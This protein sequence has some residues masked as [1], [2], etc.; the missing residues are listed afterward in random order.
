MPLLAGDRL[1]TADGRVEILFADGSTLHLDMRS[2]IDVQSDDLVRLLGGPRAADT[3]RARAGTRGLSHRLPRPARR[4]SRSRAST[5][6]RC[7]SGGRG[8]DSSSSRWCA[9]RPSSSPIEARPRVRAGERAYASAG[10]APSYAYA[11]NSAAWD[12]FDRWSEAQRDVRLGVS[13]QYLPSDMQTYASTVRRD[14]DW[15]Y[16]A[17]VRLR[18]GIRASPPTG[19]LIT[20]GA[21]IRIRAYGWTWIGADRLGLADAS[22][23]PLGIL[24]GRLVLDSRRRTGRRPRSRGRYAPGYVSWCPLGFDNR[25]VFALDT[26]ASVRATT[27][28]GARGR[29]VSCRALRRPQL[30]AVNQSAVNWRSFRRPARRTFAARPSAPRFVARRRGGQ[31]FDA[32]RA[33]PG[34]RHGRGPRAPAAG[35]R[36]TSRPRASTRRPAR[37]GVELAT[38]RPGDPASTPRY[39]NRGDEIVR[40]Q[41]ERPTPRAAAVHVAG[42]LPTRRGTAVRAS[43]DTRTFRE[44]PAR[45]RTPDHVA[46]RTAGHSRTRDR[47]DR[48]ESAVSP[49]PRATPGPGPTA[50]GLPGAAGNQAQRGNQRAA[51]Q[52]TAQPATGTAWHQAQPGNRAQPGDRAQ[53]GAAQPAARH[54][55]DRAQPAPQRQPERAAP[56]DRL[57]RAR[58]AAPQRRQRAADAAA[59]SRRGGRARC[60]AAAAVGSPEKAAPPS[61]AAPSPQAAAAAAVRRSLRCTMARYVVRLAQNAGLVV[62]F[63]LAAVPRDGQRR[64]LRVRR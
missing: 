32:D 22:L 13:A 49:H 64:A 20:T 28:R 24:G 1:R 36:A 11:Y 12:A 53:P 27:R 44:A 59:Q 17:V 7:C 42:Q 51:W 37:P 56:P 29:S 16:D 6:S 33:G 46:V 48:V 8:R 26:T 39:V 14:G 40:S 47:S 55:G 15:R 43:T 38:S 61:G 23:R 21:G 30:R 63:V 25:P 34:P 31:A 3:S 2:T 52:P 62:L 5:A 19:V 18:R 4:G 35:S 45:E 60:A 9:A 57:R 58:R 54:A 50:S 10:L 41:T